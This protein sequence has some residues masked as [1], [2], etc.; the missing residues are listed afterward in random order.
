MH[1]IYSRSMWSYRCY[2]NLIWY[3]LHLFLFNKLQHGSNF[4]MVFTTLLFLLATYTYH[5]RTEIHKVQFYSLVL[6]LRCYSLN[7]DQL[8]FPSPNLFL[9]TALIT[10]Y[11][12]WSDTSESDR[13][14][15]VGRS[16]GV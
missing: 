7:Q 12:I 13:K 16:R 8:G 14:A 11:I 3:V 6:T 1:T 9:D 4:L 5:A 10:A 15:S 2:L